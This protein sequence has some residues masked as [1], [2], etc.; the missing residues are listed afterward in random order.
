[1]AI[2]FF[3]LPRSSSSGLVLIKVQEYKRKM[4][5][6]IRYYVVEM[7]SH[8]KLDKMKTHQ[9]KRAR[10]SAVYIV[11]YENVMQHPKI[12]LNY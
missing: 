1:M 9:K 8:W 6:W 7:L 12:F 2:N 3:I 10:Q 11:C 4:E 5:G